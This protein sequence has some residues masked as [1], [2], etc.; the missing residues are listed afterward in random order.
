MAQKL[1][2]KLPGH[3]IVDGVEVWGLPASY[4]AKIAG[5]DFKGNIREGLVLAVTHGCHV[6]EAEAA[7][8]LDSTDMESAQ[9]IID[10]ILQLSGLSAVTVDVPE[11]DTDPQ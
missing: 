9:P 11:E 2:V 6:P 7:K 1:P 8:W 10:R 4:A 5:G 3:D